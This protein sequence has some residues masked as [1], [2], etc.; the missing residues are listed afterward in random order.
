MPPLMSGWEV[1][2]GVRS[3]PAARALRRAQAAAA[4]ARRTGCDISE[5]AGV[6]AERDAGSAPGGGAGL[7]AA[8]TAMSRRD[9][10]R[11]AAAAALAAAV[12]VGAAAWVSLARP[13]D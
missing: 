3:S 5:A 9:V 4:F 12:P 1:A 6:L 10:V 7:A 13:A 11:G 2:M 8:D